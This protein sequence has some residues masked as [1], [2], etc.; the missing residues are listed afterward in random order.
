MS[1]LSWRSQ[2]AKIEV[3]GASFDHELVR[4]L[5]MPWTHLISARYDNLRV[6][7]VL[8]KVCRAVLHIS[9]QSCGDRSVWD[10]HY[11]NGYL[12]ALYSRDVMNLR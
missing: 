2:S 8:G 12:H 11:A 1:A 5:P 9:I 6:V 4:E 3:I 7:Q 10:M